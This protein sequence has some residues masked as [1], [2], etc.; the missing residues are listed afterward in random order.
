MLVALD[1]ETELSGPGRQAPPLVCMSLAT[2][3]RTASLAHWSESS[4]LAD[5][6]LRSGAQIV[7][8]HIAYDFAV[9]LAHEPGLWPAV[10]AA[11][12]EDRVTDTMIREMLIANAHGELGIREFG[13]GALASRYWRKQLD[14]GED[15][16]RLRYG[17]L[18]H[19]PIAAWPDRAVS[20]AL[21][22]AQTTLDLH[23]RQEPYALELLQDQYR[24]TRAA[25]WLHMMQCRGV[26]TDPIFVE[27]Y[28]EATK[29]DHARLS[30]LLRATF[31]DVYDPKCKCRPKHAGPCRMPMLRPDRVKRNGE[32]EEGSCNQKA[33]RTRVELAYR[34]LGQPVPMTEAKKDG[35]GGGNVSYS[36]KTLQESGD[37][38]LIAYKERA[39]ANKVLTEELPILEKGAFEP[40]HARR[41]VLVESGRQACK[42]PN[43]DNRPRRFGAR[44]G[45]VPRP[46]YV[47]A[48]ADF[49]GL[50]LATMA[51]VCIALLGRSTLAAMLNDGIDP[52]AVIACQIL[53]IS[54]EEGM[55]RK[56][57][58]ADDPIFDN[59]RQCGKVVNFGRPGGLGVARLV[60]YAK[61][62]YSVELTE[63]QARDLIGIW[64]RTFPEMRAYLKLVGD[65]V[66]RQG[67]IVQL[68]SNRVRG[69]VGYTDG[70]N[71]FYQGLGSD[72]F[73]A[74]GWEILC[75][76]WDPG[77]PLFGS[78][79]VLA[80]HD[81]FILEVLD[82]SSAH[83]AAMCLGDTM[84]EAAKPW[85]PD[86]RLVADPYL[87]RR[88]SKKAKA[89]KGP[90][91]RLIPWELEG[92][93][94]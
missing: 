19:L 89:R 9:L 54:Y 36:K 37:E 16:W 58:G 13:L 68:Y 1:T 80:P 82:D 42:E 55:L 78:H 67:R 39:S 50:E 47:F 35:S 69:G 85:L 73:K 56:A 83:D 31:V 41:V 46:G 24:Q 88:W 27:C 77:S 61:Q 91:G 79:T 3:G 20:Y 2:H 23:D 32:I 52:H 59:A 60:Q 72:V 38:A 65:I 48:G 28:R 53:G 12:A 34:A 94:A 43:L 30:A 71:T 18:R 29:L 14:K 49:G 11:Y 74:A 40:V 64:V 70:C 22:D 90:D 81:E 4:A 6:L 51:Q 92:L 93:A 25:L 26:T 86:V 75:K 17:E 44:E 62:N 63:A 33:V 8:H 5:Q 45:F 76:Q 21:E 66:E 7:G 10:R 84:A 57:K 15:G 87:A